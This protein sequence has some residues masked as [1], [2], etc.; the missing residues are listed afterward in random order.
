[1]A[2]HPHIFVP[3]KG[4]N[5]PYRG[6]TPNIPVDRVQRENRR[7]HTDELVQA[8]EAAVER[9]AER[10]AQQVLL[11]EDER[12]FYLSF[13]APS[14][15]PLP[16]KFFESSRR[17]IDLLSITTGDEKQTANVFMRA[18]K[19]HRFKQA[20]EAY[21]DSEPG[22]GDR[23]NNEEF[24]DRLERIRPSKLSDL[25]TDQGELPPIGDDF[26]WELWLRP[27]T[28]DWVRDTAPELGIDVEPGHLLFPETV[29]V[30]AYCSPRQL[31]RL[32]RKVPVVAELRAASSFM[33]H[34]LDF[35]PREQAD[36]AERLLARV[37]EPD[38]N[39]PRVCI[40]DSGVRRAHPLL[41]PFLET[42]RCL[43]INAAWSASDH[44]GHGTGMAGVALYENLAPHLQ[45]NDPVQITHRLES[46]TVLPPSIPGVAQ[47]LP[48][49]SVQD[50][51]RLA[52]R[53]A[54]AKRIYSLSMS[55]PRERSD[56]R[57]SSLSTAIDQLAFGR[58]GK[59]R[60]FFVPAGN[61]DE[62]PYRG[63]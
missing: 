60:L 17:G 3:R 14:A 47:P 51:V 55:V 4:R 30:R 11:P 33:A 58:P 27:G 2:D 16:L 9:N 35:S 24:F 49:T 1:M 13:E 42:G 43:T 22:V 36:E 10:M 18:S 12:G 38:A 28:E 31:Q 44:H 53:S 21:A 46:V 61:I 57:P 15:T 62:H 23:P 19:A 5:I 41:A 37:V 54:K 7:A 48:G 63:R 50:G 56:G 40:L 52:E 59:Q 45:S 6:I 26:A 25:W 8:V 39:A 20:T 29:V 32:V 34:L